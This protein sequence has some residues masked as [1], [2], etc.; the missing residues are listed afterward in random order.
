MRTT[1]VIDRGLL[2]QV[3]K[4]TGFS[5]KEAVVE[6][7][8]RLLVKMKSQAGIGRLRGKISSIEN[9]RDLDNGRDCS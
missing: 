5:T 1:I 6:E 2:R 7:G 9:V 4:L 3:M 8:L